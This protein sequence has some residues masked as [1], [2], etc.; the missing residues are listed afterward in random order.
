MGLYGKAPKPPDYS[1]IANAQ[2]ETGKQMMEY[3]NK[4]FE[5]AKIQNEKMYNLTKEVTDVQLAT[6][7]DQSEFAK[8]ERERYEKDFLPMEEK[9]RKEAEEYDTPD[10]RAAASGRAI[11]DVGSAMD[12]ERDASARRLASFG[13]DPSMLRSGALDLQSRVAAGA[14]KAKAGTDAGLQV[15]DTGR[16]MRAAAIN[17]GRGLPAQSVSSAQTGTGAGGA[18]AGAGQGAVGTGMGALN[19]SSRWG[20]GASGA[21]GGAGN[22]LSQ[23][24]QDALGAYTANQQYGPAG[25]LQTITGGIAGAATGK[26]FEEGGPVLPEDSPSRGLRTDD[27]KANVNVGEY[28]VPKEVVRWKGEEFFEKLKKQVA[29]AMPRASTPVLA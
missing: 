19:D 9:F 23:G 2:M 14:I 11:A 13:V 7:K 22:A 18:A 15:E 4:T 28:I 16:A 8:R 27:V 6:A 25:M 29:E 24:Y 5:E 3:M 12:A 1:P 20:V 10:R 26:F 21:F 17:L